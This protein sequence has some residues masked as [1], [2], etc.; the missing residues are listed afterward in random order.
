MLEAGTVRK[1]KIIKIVEF[2]VY[3]A[4]EEK[5]KEKEKVLLPKKQV[6]E[7]AKVGD[8][9]EVFLY[10]D[11][12]DRLIAT[13]ARPK[14]LLHE[15]ALLRVKDTSR[16][17]A[18]MDWGL[19]K[20][21]LLPFHEQ[22]KKVKAGDEVLC[23][24][25]LDKSGRL[26]VTMNV[27]PYLRKDSPYHKDD[28]V[29]GIVYEDSDNFGLFVAVDDLYSAL[30]PKNELY[31]EVRIG[32]R[33]SCRVTRVR[34]DGKLSLSLREKAYLQMSIDADH[35][36]RYLGANRGEIPFTDKADPALIREKMQMSKN[37]FKKAVGN[38]LKAGKI[39]IGKD[40]IVQIK[41][42]K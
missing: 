13:T 39:Q 10:K 16:I 2:G 37:E 30:I 40:K 32:D 21:V 15:V 12:E 9:L 1:L 25:Y 4:E 22:T 36:M 7:E 17:G 14:L 11:S 31:G 27:Y 18:F 8:F 23:A 29:S 26:A 41:N 35:L 6:P 19:E 38:L 33:V 20:D 28:R 24:L 34:E 5:E 3:L 42:G